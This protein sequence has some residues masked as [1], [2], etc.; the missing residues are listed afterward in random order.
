MIHGIGIDH[1]EISR[2]E[3][4]VIHDD[5][6]ATRVFTAAEIAYCRSQ[7][8]PAQHFAARFCA[9]EAFFKALGTGWRHGMDWIEIEVR[10]DAQG[11]PGIALTGK[12]AQ[13]FCER[14]CGRIFLSMSH[15]RETAMAMV[16]IETQEDPGE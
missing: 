15:S 3:R 6:F 14:G 16:T 5:G 2:M 12:A 8:R 7:C 13:V 4:L 1:L 9:K 10:R 11:C